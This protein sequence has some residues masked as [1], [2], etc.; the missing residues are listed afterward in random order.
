MS[1]L[2]FGATHPCAERFKVDDTHA[3]NAAR[4][5]H[6]HR[7]FPFLSVPFLSDAIAMPMPMPIS[8]LAS[9]RRVRNAQYERHK[10]ELT[11]RR[12]AA[13]SVMAS[14]QHVLCDDL[15]AHP[16]FSEAR[17][18]HTDRAG[19]SLIRYACTIIIRLNT[20]D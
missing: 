10:R 19:A 1:A 15:R 2:I 7:R 5:G 13:G 16:R 6:R 12:C 17:L 20:E 4:L 11:L 14:A 3:R 18:M 8:M 9:S